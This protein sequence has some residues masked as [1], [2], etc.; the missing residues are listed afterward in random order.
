M[1]NQLKPMETNLNIFYKRYKVICTRLDCPSSFLN[2]SLQTLPLNC[3]TIIV[4]FVCLSSLTCGMLCEGLHFVFINSS[5][6][7]MTRTCIVF[8]RDVCFSCEY[9]F[10][11]VFFIKLETILKSKACCTFSYN[12]LQ[13]NASV[14]LKRTTPPYCPSILLKC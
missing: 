11:K 7:K 2:S 3:I 1:L 8:V 9:C 4:V 14:D 10:G 13:Q 12:Q 6:F 5:C